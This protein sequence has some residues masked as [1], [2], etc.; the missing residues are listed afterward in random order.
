MF[1]LF[2]FIILV[3]AAT[4]A[5]EIEENKQFKRFREL[6]NL[7]NDPAGSWLVCANPFKSSNTSDFLTKAYTK[8]DGQGHRVTF[9]N[10]TWTVPSYPAI[11]FGSNAPGL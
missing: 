8:S 6:K 9:V 5:I 7:K 4:N 2:G 3:A 10:A 1:F 11:D